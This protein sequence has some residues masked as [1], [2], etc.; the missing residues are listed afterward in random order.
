MHRGCEEVTQRSLSHVSIASAASEASTY[1]DAEENV[2][3]STSSIK[4]GTFT[5]PDPCLAHL[6]GIVSRSP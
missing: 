4:T 5:F 1:F 2:P 3:D 6:S